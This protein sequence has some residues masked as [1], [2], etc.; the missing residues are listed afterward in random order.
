MF[1]CHLLSMGSF[2]DGY[3]DYIQ[4][5]SSVSGHRMPCCLFPSRCES[6][7]NVSTIPQNTVIR[8]SYT[9]RSRCRCCRLF[10]D[11]NPSAESQFFR[12]SRSFISAR[13]F[14]EIRVHQRSNYRQSESPAV[15]FRRQDE[16]SAESR[17]EFNFNSGG[18]G[19]Q[20]RGGF[21]KSSPLGVRNT[22]SHA[23][24]AL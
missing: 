9:G 15:V 13:L 16:V 18:S 10:A 19:K 3:V 5:L 7:I 21:L 23:I 12:R 11:H 24:I 17:S 4:Q 22:A 1:T 14:K 6:G 8:Q 2:Q 20:I